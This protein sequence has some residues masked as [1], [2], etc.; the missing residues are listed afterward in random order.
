MAALPASPRYLPPQWTNG[1]LWAESLPV[2]PCI[3]V[4]QNSGEPP[5]VSAPPP[6]RGMAS[7][8]IAASRFFVADKFNNLAAPTPDYASD[9]ARGLSVSPSDASTGHRCEI[10]PLQHPR[11]SCATSNNTECFSPMRSSRMVARRRLSGECSYQVSADR[12][13][14]L[15]NTLIPPNRSLTEM[16]RATVG[17]PQ[18]ELD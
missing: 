3:A 2:L 15:G 6:A 12:A 14:G 7:A 1:R 4:S 10:R 8:P 13:G 5:V 9:R 18:F 16:A 11:C 17:N